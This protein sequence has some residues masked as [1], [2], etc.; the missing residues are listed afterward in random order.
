MD[1]VLGMTNE[2]ENIDR[3][4]V[5]HIQLG[6]ELH[7]AVTMRWVAMQ[8]NVSPDVVRYRMQKMREEGVVDW[9]DMPGSV[10]VLRPEAVVEDTTDECPSVDAAPSASS[11]MEPPEE[12]APPSQDSVPGSATAPRPPK[13]NRSPVAPDPR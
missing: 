12:T 13:R 5:S 11:L 7:N 1:R 6:R 3:A 8:I 2:Y 4:I 10:V 9:N